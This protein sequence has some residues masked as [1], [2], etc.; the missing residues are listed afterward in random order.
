MDELNLN[1]DNMP[2]L[3]D[4][5]SILKPGI[6]NCIVSEAAVKISNNP[7]NL[8]YL[9]VNFEVEDG[10]EMGKKFWVSLNYNHANET[11]KKIALQHLRL[12]MENLNIKTTRTTDDLVGARAHLTV[13]HRTYTG[14]DGQEHT[15]ID[16]KKWERAENLSKPSLG[17]PAPAASS[18]TTPPWKRG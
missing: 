15:T 2:E 12:L 9:N 10:P 6:Y 11:T 4:G 8:R 13:A 5:Y 1:M 7:N 17:T 14:S 18:S 16:V 3:D